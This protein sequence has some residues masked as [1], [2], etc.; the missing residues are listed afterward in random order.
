MKTFYVGIKAIIV[1]DNKILLLHAQDPIKKRD[2]WEA[3]GGRIDDDETIQQALLRE[4]HEEVP[5]IRDVNVG[6]ALDAYR[7]PW[8]VKDD[9]S[10]V[11]IFYKVTAKF[12]GEPQISDEHTEYK[13]VDKDEALTMVEE[14]TRMAINRVFEE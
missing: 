1:Q 9:K 6:N 11:L 3:P 14:T 4:L 13:W 10:L 2:Y 12:D 8:D 5:N 7:L